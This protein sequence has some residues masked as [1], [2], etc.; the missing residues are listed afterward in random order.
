MINPKK[1]MKIKMKKKVKLIVIQTSKEEFYQDHQA[2]E[3]K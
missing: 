1:L 2:I 3:N